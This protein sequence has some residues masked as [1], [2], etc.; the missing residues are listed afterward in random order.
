[1]TVN[2]RVTTDE[3]KTIAA[4][5][6]RAAKLA[7]EFN[8]SYPLMEAEMDVTAAHA[9]GCPLDLERLLAFD[10]ENFSHDVFGIRRH[11]DRNTGALRDCF[12][13][14]CARPES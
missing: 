14:R 2:F 4:I 7:A 5:A 6:D 10:D 11:I 3:F 13:P 1:V 8:C 12:L 9:N